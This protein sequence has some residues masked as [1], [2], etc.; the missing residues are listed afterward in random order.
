MHRG[1]GEQRPNSK[2]LDGEQTKPNALG[3]VAF[4]GMMG[5]P[6]LVDRPSPSNLFLLVAFFLSPATT[7]TLAALRSCPP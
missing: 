2:P 1:R 6:S 4:S 7:T 5:V 3:P